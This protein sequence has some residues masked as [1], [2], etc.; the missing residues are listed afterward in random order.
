MVVIVQG[1][2]V[3]LWVLHWIPYYLSG[4]TANY[5][6]PNDSPPWILQLLRGPAALLWAIIKFALGI[7]SQKQ[8]VE[9]IEAT[10][11]GAASVAA[12]FRRED[13]IVLNTDKRCAFDAVIVSCKATGID[14]PCVTT[15][16]IDEAA[17][18]RD[19]LSYMANC[20]T[21]ATQV[22]RDALALADQAPTISWKCPECDRVTHKISEPITN[23]AHWTFWTDVPPMRAKCKHCDKVVVCQGDRDATQAWRVLLRDNA[24]PIAIGGEIRRD[25]GVV[26]IPKAYGVR[27]KRD[28]RRALV[29]DRPH[30][31]RMGG[32]QRLCT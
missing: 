7:P 3:F 27:G 15:P 18:L 29:G 28:V 24:D 26:M 23:V 31:R 16:G 9:I 32:G 14:L 6:Q 17:Q 22:L 19:N 21:D 13:G 10:R 8:A 1:F 4:G 11:R 2:F 12:F 25:T 30:D 5:L 20:P